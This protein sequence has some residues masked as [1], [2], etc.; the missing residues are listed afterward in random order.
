MN[1]E[2]TA[3]ISAAMETAE[4]NQS[5]LARMIGVRKSTVSMWMSAHQDR[6]P[7]RA[8]LKKIAE[9]LGVQIEWLT[10]GGEMKQAIPQETINFS[11]TKYDP[12]REKKVFNA[13]TKLMHK[14]RNALIKLDDISSNID[15]KIAFDIQALYTSNNCVIT[16]RTLIKETEAKSLEKDRANIGAALWN[17]NIIQMLDE[18]MGVDR[19]GILAIYV[20]EDPESESELRSFTLEYLIEQQGEFASRAGIEIITIYEP[21]QIVDLIAEIEDIEHLM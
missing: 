14:V 7:K 16:L 8:N 15:R 6:A 12:G 9:V 13:Q 19:R 5:D 21:E 18:D 2:I 4:L 3:R 10:D 11:P 20:V 17:L 1:N